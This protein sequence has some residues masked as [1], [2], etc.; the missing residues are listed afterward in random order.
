MNLKELA[1]TTPGA[2]G[3]DLENIINQA[4]LLAYINKSKEIR[5]EDI[6]QAEDKVLLGTERKSAIIPKNVIENTA[7]II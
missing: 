6:L 3:A 7:Y 5:M 2:S 1:D 4:A